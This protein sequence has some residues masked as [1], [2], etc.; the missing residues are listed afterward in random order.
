MIAALCTVPELVCVCDRMV[1][2]WRHI[3]EACEKRGKN[4]KHVLSNIIN[5]N[6]III[7]GLILL[8]ASSPQITTYNTQGQTVTKVKLGLITNITLGLY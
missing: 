5:F 1:W 3:Q 2:E 7:A 4:K 6:I 8:P